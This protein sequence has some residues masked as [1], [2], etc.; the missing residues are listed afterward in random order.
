VVSGVTDERPVGSSE[1]KREEA[2]ELPD[3]EG[4]YDELR[5]EAARRQETEAGR[6]EA[7]DEVQVAKEGSDSE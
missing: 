5:E 1:L 4:T 3:R 7:A 2:K 6:R